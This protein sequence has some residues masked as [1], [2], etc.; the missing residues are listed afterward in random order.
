MAACKNELHPLEAWNRWRTVYEQRII[1]M[2][3]AGLLSLL[4]T[5]SRQAHARRKGRAD[6]FSSPLPGRTEQNT[7]WLWEALGRPDALQAFAL[8]TLAASPFPAVSQSHGT[9][10]QQSSGLF[11]ANLRLSC[12]ILQPLKHA[13]PLFR[14]LQNQANNKYLCK[15]LNS[16]NE[17]QK[18]FLSTQKDAAGRM[19]LHFAASSVYTQRFRCLFFFCQT[20]TDNTLNFLKSNLLIFLTI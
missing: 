8:P 7:P 4:C 6:P 18:V 19:K 11:L 20:F 3:S 2:S 16:S 10:S 12:L 9:I 1:P 14:C 15:V 13:V 5:N 17:G